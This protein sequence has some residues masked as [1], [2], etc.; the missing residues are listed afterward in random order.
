MNEVYEGLMEAVLL[1][2]STYWLPTRLVAMPIGGA[3]LLL[4]ARRVPLTEKQAR[5]WVGTY[6]MLL[7]PFAGEG[8][9]LLLGIGL[10]CI[11]FAW[12]RDRGAELLATNSNSSVEDRP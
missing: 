7:I 12:V 5:F 11:G 8:L 3:I 2:G 1:S 10:L 4:M 6:L 9:V